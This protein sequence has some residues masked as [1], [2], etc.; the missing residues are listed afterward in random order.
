MTSLTS[1]QIKH[2]IKTEVTNLGFIL[3]GFTTPEPID[4]FSKYAEW[5][6]G[7]YHADMSYLARTS[8]MEKRLNP[9]QLMP[10]VQSILILGIP[11]PVPNTEL[12]NTDPEM[13]KIASYAQGPDYH[14]LIL[15]KIKDLSGWLDNLIGHHVNFRIF[16]DTAPV[17]EK[18]L[19]MRAGL[20]WIGR[21]GLLINP[22][23]GSF[24]FLTEVF[25]DLEIPPDLP[26]KADLCGNCNRCVESCPTSC[27]MTNRTLDANRCIS[28][29]TIEKKEV[30]SI[31]EAK[32][33]TDSVFGC[34]ACQTV[35]PWNQKRM[36]KD[37]FQSLFLPKHQLMNTS[38]KDLL[39]LDD[40]TFNEKYKDTPVSRTKREGLIR[41]ILASIG[42]IGQAGDLEKLEEFIAAEE[43]E[44]LRMLAS[45][46][47]VQ[48][49]NRLDGKY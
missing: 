8:S 4:G 20:G 37:E 10:G 22:H 26:F 17:M 44:N 14:D 34:D 42:N 25:L 9:K 27:I 45:N 43:N 24:F 19:G 35:C 28:Y 31:E 39:L 3:N 47:Q 1:S 36:K 13:R 38:T 41:N 30:F 49:I 32:T 46:A 5:I 12:L 21:N 2:A 7:G 29:L 6:N 15:E 48:L 11:Y 16:T 33:I 40:K 18:E 23:V